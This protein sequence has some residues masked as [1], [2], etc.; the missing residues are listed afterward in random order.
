MKEILKR[1]QEERGRVV[2]SAWQFG[3]GVMARFEMDSNINPL[4][5]WVV[6]WGHSRQMKQHVLKSKDVSEKGVSRDV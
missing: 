6:K 3:D 2:N 4:L 5:I 1:L